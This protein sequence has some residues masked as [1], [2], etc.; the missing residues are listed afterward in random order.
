M[1]DEIIAL[2]KMVNVSL[3]DMPII[4]YS[5]DGGFLYLLRVST[6]NY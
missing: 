4:I 1:L 2:K 5:A 6:I 3:V